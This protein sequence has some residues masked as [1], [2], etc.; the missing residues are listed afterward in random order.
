MG[1]G[2]RTLDLRTGSPEPLACQARLGLAICCKGSSGNA[3]V[4]CCNAGAAHGLKSRKSLWKA[5]HHRSSSPKQMLDR[6]SLRGKLPMH[7]TGGGV[8]PEVLVFL[9]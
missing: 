3:A 7:Y 8:A 2:G 4:K 1:N 9:R 5:S 6:E